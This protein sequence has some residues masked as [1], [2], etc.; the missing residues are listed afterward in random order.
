MNLGIEILENLPD[1]F[2]DKYDQI[3]DAIFG[4]SFKGDVRSPFDKIL[5]LLAKTKLPISSV[6]IPSGWDVEKGP[7]EGRVDINPKMLISLTAPKLCAKKYQGIHWLGGRFVPK[8]M[9]EE[10]NLPKY[11]GT[12]QVVLLK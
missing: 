10:L 12:E 3:V 1:D 6:D 5:N 11:E 9:A 8:K 7:V 4:Y 2:E